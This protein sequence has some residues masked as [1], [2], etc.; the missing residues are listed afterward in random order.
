MTDGGGQVPRIHPPLQVFY[1]TI[2]VQYR[3]GHPYMPELHPDGWLRVDAV[4]E[5]AAREAVHRRLDNKWA[6][7][8][9]PANFKPE[10][11]PR[12]ELAR[13]TVTPEQE[14]SNGEG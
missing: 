2:G 14:Q 9:T 1:V 8:Y 12:G 3:E 4:D 10:H 6:F 7:I 11:F 5:D 13:L